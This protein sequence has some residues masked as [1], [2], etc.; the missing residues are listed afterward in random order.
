MNLFVIQSMLGIPLATLYRG[1]LP[2]V[3]VD[4]VRLGLMVAFPWL[5]LFLPNLGR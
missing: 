2:F 5:I 3:V 1:I 4:I